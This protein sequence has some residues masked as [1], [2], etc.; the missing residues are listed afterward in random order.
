MRSAISP[1]SGGPITGSWPCAMR[2]RARYSQRGSAE[3]PIEE[4]T[5]DA[6][7]TAHPS[8]R[9]DGNGNHFQLAMLAYNRN[10]RLMPRRSRQLTP[11][12]VDSVTPSERGGTARRR[13]RG[14]LSRAPKAAPPN[15]LS[16]SRMVIT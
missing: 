11:L 1:L 16:F 13:A 4:A 9:F 15:V 14:P 2:K 7:L 8:H 6:G 12:R 10:C 3:N 5:T